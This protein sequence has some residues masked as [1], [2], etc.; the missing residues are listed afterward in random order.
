MIEVKGASI[1]SDRRLNWVICAQERDQRRIFAS[2]LNAETAQLRCL[3]GFIIG[4]SHKIESL[5]FKTP[6]IYRCR[7]P[8]T[9]TFDPTDKKYQVSEEFPPNKEETWTYPKEKDGE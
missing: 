9:M 4:I 1:I 5:I 3:R 8:S 2:V 6:S 7:S